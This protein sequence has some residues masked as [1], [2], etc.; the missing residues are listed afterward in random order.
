MKRKRRESRCALCPF[1]DCEE[2]QKVICEGVI[3]NTHIHLCFDTPEAL[4]EYKR[5]F[6]YDDYESCIIHTALC[7][8]YEDG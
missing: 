5:K 8:K 2:A 1:Y 6:C 4:K 3:E 7:T